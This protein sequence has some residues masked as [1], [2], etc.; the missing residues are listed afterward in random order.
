MTPLQDYERIR[1]I[2]GYL[3]VNLSKT[4]LD[5]VIICGTVNTNNISKT[6]EMTL[7]YN[8]TCY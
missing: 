3:G 8:I 1:S 5:V 6:R 2:T 4:I 7:K